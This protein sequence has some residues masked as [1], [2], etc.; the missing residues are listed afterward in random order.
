M[1]GANL[2]KIKTPTKKSMPIIKHKPT[3][4]EHPNNVD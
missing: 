1:I 2:K 4:L 3:T